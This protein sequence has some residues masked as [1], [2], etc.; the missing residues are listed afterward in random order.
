M[1]FPM[2]KADDVLNIDELAA[3]LKISK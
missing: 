1:V 2:E 3:Y